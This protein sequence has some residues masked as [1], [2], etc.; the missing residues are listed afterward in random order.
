VACPGETAPASGSAE[1]DGTTTEFSHGDPVAAD[2]FEEGPR[3]VAALGDKR[4]ARAATLGATAMALAVRRSQTVVCLTFREGQRQTAWEILR[5]P[6]A[7]RA[8]R[9]RAAFLEADGA[10]AQL[11]SPVPNRR[12]APLHFRQAE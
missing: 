6:H 3:I 10:R 4:P 7:S 5:Q 8:E 11:D 12:G 1:P 9:E 2:D